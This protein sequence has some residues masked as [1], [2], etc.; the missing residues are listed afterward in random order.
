VWGVLIL[1]LFF[2]SASCTLFLGLLLL[3]LQMDRDQSSI[4]GRPFIMTT[5]VE[6]LLL[7]LSSD[8]VGSGLVDIW[9]QGNGSALR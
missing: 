5:Y 8:F 9:L 7:L 4:G 1:L 2:I 3:V 6:R